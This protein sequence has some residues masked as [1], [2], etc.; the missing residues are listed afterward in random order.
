MNG[1]RIVIVHQRAKL[2]KILVIELLVIGYWL[3]VICYLLLSYWSKDSTIQQLNDYTLN[4]THYTQTF[5]IF[6][7][8]KKITYLCQYI[9]TKSKNYGYQTTQ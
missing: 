7:K 3:L 2:V 4:I 5:P 6:Q 9:K 8:I 1:K